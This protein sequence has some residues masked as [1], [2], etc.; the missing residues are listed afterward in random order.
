M[1]RTTSL[2]VD[3]RGNPEHW[4]RLMKL[5]GREELI[6]TRAT[7][8]A[9]PG[10]HEAEVDAIVTG[11]TRKHT[12]EEAMVIIGDVGVPAGGSSTRSN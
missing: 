4:A 12:K 6:G 3:S 1:D 11:W 9:R 5:F 8:R 7:R 2:R 10:Q